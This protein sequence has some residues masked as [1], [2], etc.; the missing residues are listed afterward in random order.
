MRRIHIVAI[1]GR[2]GTTLLAEAMRACFEIDGFHDREAGIAARSTGTAIHLSKRPGDIER[3][4]P[5]LRL[6][7]RLYVVCMVRDPRDVIVSENWSRPGRYFIPLWEVRKGLAHLRHYAGHPRF[8]VVRYEDLASDP[9]GAQRELERRMPFLR[10]TADFR[11]F[12]RVATGVSKGNADDM[13]GVRPIDAASIGNWRRHLPR[14]ADQKVGLTR[15]L[16]E[17]GYEQDASWERALDGVTP[18]RQPPLLGDESARALWLPP[19]LRRPL[20][21]LWRLRRPAQRKVASSLEG[22]SGLLE[23]VTRAARG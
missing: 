22:I 8:I 9:S 23:Y 10:R 21:R 14:V 19:A 7:P 12:H 4:G 18:L 15:A 13:H 6:D 3:I 5:R 2:T 16:I 20:L 11:D 1:A 17:L